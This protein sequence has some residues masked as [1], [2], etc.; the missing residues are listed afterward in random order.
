ML[1]R[2][3][4]LAAWVSVGVVLYHLFVVGHGMSWLGVFIP[5]EMHEA[6]SLLLACLVIYI[7]RR[8][9]SR[10]H[11]R[12]ATWSLGAIP[13]YD[14]L[15][16]A[17]LLVG[18]GFVMFFFPAIDDYA[19]YG[20]LDT[21]GIVVAALLCVAVL[22]AVRRSTG[23]ALPIII[24]CF[25]AITLYQPYLPGI[26][27]GQGFPIDQILYSSFI[28]ENGIFGAPLR[29]ATTLIIIYLMFGA[30]MEAIG[31]GQWIMDLAMAATGWSRGG[32]AKAAVVASAM[33]GSISGSP[34]GNA[35]TIGVFTIPL[36][37][38]I[39]YRPAFAGATEAVASTGG[40]ILPPVMGSIAFVMADWL[41]MSYRD[42]AIS[43]ALPAILYFI[44]VFASVHF[45][46]RVAGIE[47]MRRA[48]LPRVWPILRRGWHFIIPLAALIYFL[49]VRAYPPELA[50][51]YSILVAI[52][53][54]FLTR[55]RSL[56]M[57]W[58]KFVRA[59]E[60]SV[61]RW[62]PICAITGAVGIMVGAL[63]LSG[64]GI[65]ISDF[66]VAL[67]GGNLP[68][69]LLMV[70]VT[71]LI[72]GMGL[73]SLPAYITLAT[74]LAPA[75]IKLSVSPLAAH[76]FVVY[77]GLASFYTPPMCLAISVVITISGSGVWETGWEAVRLG[78]AAFLVPFAFVFD[79]GLLFEGSWPHIAAAFCTAAIGAI[80]LAAA[81]QGYAFG[82]LRAWVRAIV[83]LGGLLLVSPSLTLSLAG[84]AAI[85][86]AL[87]INRLMAR[88]DIRPATTTVSHPRPEIVPADAL[89]RDID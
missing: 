72:V 29:V 83:A 28:G 48:D 53:S 25:V 59:C 3:G 10:G 88:P 23:I 11:Q 34:S 37:K 8:I 82:R 46:A 67:S 30:T 54:S 50:G 80:A 40:Q 33:F 4:T 38:S 74:L 36:M 78:I 21:R 43:A 2:M 51:I 16:I 75:M 57:T 14:Y 84:L 9:A 77:W 32:P 70:G 26:L 35:A 31:A 19:M 66:I 15:F 12:T 18:T 76:L 85:A 24:L 58:P 7:T 22:E 20:M 42:V 86:V 56:W 52:A 61:R 62:A 44:V 89:V 87:G 5:G 47:A 81:I 55:D 1:R 68:L 17:A 27:H 73:D 49:L 63:A 71:A 60:D 45:Q 6:V 69:L 79:N 65:K 64:V 41:G 39:G 13:W